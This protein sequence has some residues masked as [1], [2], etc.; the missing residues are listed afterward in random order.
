MRTRLSYHNTLAC[1]LLSLLLVSCS[2]TGSRY[3]MRHDSAPNTALNPQRIAN[4]VP[5]VEP[6]SQYGNPDSYVVN[7]KR[8]HVMETANGFSQRGIASWYGRKFH[9]H[10]TSSGEAYDMFAMTAAHKSLPIP[11]YVKVT[12]LQ[13]QRQVIVRVNDRGPF[14]DNRIID[15]SYAAATKL[16]IAAHGTGQ[17]EIEA[18]NPR[19]YQQARLKQRPYALQALERT[20]SAEKSN[21]T[22]DKKAVDSKMY[23]QLG[24]FVSR[25]NAEQLQQRASQIHLSASIAAEQQAD[26]PIYRVRIGPLASTEEADQLVNQLKQQG[27]QAAQIVID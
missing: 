17:V 14:H 19:T 7:G 24:A 5:R 11:C 8:Y 13:N 23:L 6:I 18:I 2:S 25:V 12:N 21:D 20:H 16:G 22:N 4:A 9:G 27:F 3:A 1:C 26:Q 15:L 10:R